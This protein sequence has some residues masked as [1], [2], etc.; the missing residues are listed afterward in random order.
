MCFAC[1]YWEML[2]FVAWGMQICLSNVIDFASY[3]RL[4]LALCKYLKSNIKQFSGL[5]LL[6]FISFFC[7]V[8]VFE[9]PDLLSKIRE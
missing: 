4:A 5:D 6:T 9:F 8:L 2:C 7:E 3:Q 1:L